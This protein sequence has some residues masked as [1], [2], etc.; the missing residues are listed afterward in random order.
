MLDMG[1]FAGGLM[2]Y[3]RGKEIARLTIGG[4]IG[5]M[6]KLAQ[7]ATDLH[8]S[9][10]QVDFEVLADWAGALGLDAAAVRGANTAAEA[11]EIGGAALCA[12]IAERARDN[13]QAFLGVGTTVD[14]L[15]IDRAGNILAVAK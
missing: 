12:E 3:L 10:S 4:G 11:G 7:G 2:K 1:D 14:V 5:K 8:S 9:R 6:T 15:V 13:A